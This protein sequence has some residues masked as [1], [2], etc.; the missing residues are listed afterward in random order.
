MDFS[1]YLKKGKSASYG[2]SDRERNGLFCGK[3]L[4]D[5]TSISY[6]RSFCDESCHTQYVQNGIQS[7]TPYRND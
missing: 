5:K 3:V 4:E 7:R 2:I 6:K 1:P